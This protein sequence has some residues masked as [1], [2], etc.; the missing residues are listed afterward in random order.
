M[1]GGAGGMGRT[2]W[3]EAPVDS[4]D[5]TG[6]VRDK[7]TVSEVLGSEALGEGHSGESRCWSA[8]DMATTL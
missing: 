5:D 3:E 2:G 7:P 1:G 6:K 4:E 8:G